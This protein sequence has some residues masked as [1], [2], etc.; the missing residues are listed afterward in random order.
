MTT[1]PSFTEKLIKNRIDARSV[2]RG[3]TYA[4]NGAIVA[5]QAQ[6]N[7]LKGQCYGSRAT[8]YHVSAE[9]S[10]TS[11]VTAS[12]T[13][14]VG[15]GGACKHVAA[16]LFAWINDSSQFVA[17]SSLRQKLESRSKNQLLDFI[18]QLVRQHPE[19]TTTIMN[20]PVEAS[21]VNPELVR[22]QV[23]GALEETKYSDDYYGAAN[24]AAN[25]ILE[26]A[27][28][29][30]QLVGVNNWHA[31]ATLFTTIANET[32]PM[33]DQIHDHDGDLYR[34]IYECS[35]RLDACLDH[36]EEM[37]TRETILRTLY[38]IVAKDIMVGGY[39]FGDMAYDPLLQQSNS[40][41]KQMIAQ[42]VKESQGGVGS[43]K[44]LSKWRN[45]S[46]GGLLLALQEDEIS[47]EQ[48]IALCLESDRL[49]DA[50][51]R[52][53]ALGRVESAEDVART[54]SDYEL[55][56]IADLFVAHDQG[57]HGAALVL[58]RKEK[59][60]DRRIDPWLQ[61][62]AEKTGDWASALNFSKDQFTAR[63]S[64]SFYQDL[65][66]VA[67]QNSKWN[68]VRE[69]I[70]KRLEDD[71]KFETLIDIA[72]HEKQSGRALD[73]LDKLHSRKNR[74]GRQDFDERR[75]VL[76]AESAEASHPQHASEI[77]RKIA[78]K[79]IAARGRDN[80]REAAK[81]LQR[82]K[83]IAL[84]SGQ[85]EQWKVLI[86]R[87]RI[88]NKTLRAMKDEFNRAGL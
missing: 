47:D 78:E 35:E 68:A 61:K 84:K 43:D 41:E 65:Q 11:L 33:I 87:L 13:C 5:P 86:E 18:E 52:L 28:Q 4:R 46:L 85:K 24:V 74:W 34:V 39:G 49:G 15:G 36:I 66:R 54:A 73:Y 27:E 63:P 80:Y 64:L 83:A 88:E 1:I 70:I 60:N 21:E 50:V 17:T 57:K 16:L 14:P 38:D 67:Q 40:V 19:I 2:S 79:L 10:T 42:W 81:L 23:Q 69:E 22:R 56:R 44:F 71:K 58:K 25:K 75:A 6:G 53:L 51:D 26:S 62:Y 3:R 30:R 72:I 82:V 9:F 20:M 76:V 8:P 48:Y 77:Y 55:L 37:N 31:V 29:M 7:I 12:C 59:S 45:Q 32:L